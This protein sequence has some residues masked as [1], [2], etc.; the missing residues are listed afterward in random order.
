MNS[1]GIAYVPE[2]LS[3]CSEVAPSAAREHSGEQAEVDQRSSVNVLD[4]NTSDEILLTATGNGSKEALAFLFRRHRRTVS[5]IA[6]RILR[7]PSEAEDLCQDVFLLLFQ[8]A[9]LFDASKGTASSWIIQITYHR[10]MNRREYLSHREHYTAHELNEEQV[11]TGKQLFV[12]EIVARNL[13]N[14]VR[15]Q[16]SAEQQ[17]TLELHYFEGYSL[18]EIAQKTNQTLGNIRHHYY[19]GLERLRSIVFPQK[20]V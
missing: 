16:L 3:R 17:L 9:K 10:A 11:D 18:R 19:R 1:D 12:D 6:L 4:S 7:D 13:L 14:R 5:N 15:G 20:D 8:K 2:L